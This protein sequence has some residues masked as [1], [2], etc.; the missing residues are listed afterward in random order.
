MKNNGILFLVAGAAVGY[1][2]RELTASAERRRLIEQ[3]QAHGGQADNSTANL[4]SSI[5]G[6]IGSTGLLTNLFG[7]NTAT[8]PATTVQGY[9]DYTIIQ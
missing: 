6:L 8:A 2:I 3:I 1:G 9:N 4:F 7:G 5:F